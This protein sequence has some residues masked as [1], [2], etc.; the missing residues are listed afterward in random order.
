M[1]RQPYSL[2]GRLRL[3]AIVAVISA[4]LLAGLA[5]ALILHRFVVGQVDQRL[6]TQILAIASALHRDADGKLSVTSVLNGPPYDRPVSGWVWQVSG[7]LGAVVSPSLGSARPVTLPNVPPDRIESV[8]GMKDWAGIWRTWGRPKSADGNAAD[9]RDLHWRVLAVPFEQGTVT[10]AAGAPY[11]AISGPLRDALLPLALA[12]AIL[13]V[14][15]LGALFAQVR[16]G[17]RPLNGLRAGLAEIRAGRA[18][19]LSAD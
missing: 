2:A 4:L 8:F 6:D 18:N 3:V 1:N 15:L 17:L 5:I 7:P 10:V 19:A 11:R 13:G 9:G 14:L 12:L 16:L